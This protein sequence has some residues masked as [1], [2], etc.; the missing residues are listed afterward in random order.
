MMKYSPRLFLALL[1]ATALTAPHAAIAQVDPANGA[2]VYEAPNGVPIVDIVNPDGN[3]LSHNKFNQYNVDNRG[4]ILNNGTIAQTTH[5]SQLAGQVPANMN[6]G[7]SATVILN[8]VVS[9]NRS[10]LN[11]FTEV[12]GQ[13]ADVIVANPYGITCNGCGFINAPNATLTTGAPQF[14][15]GALTGFRTEEGD[16]L[17]TGA[18][19]NAQD[20]DYLALV[21]RSVTVDGQVNASDLDVVAGANDW[22][23]NNKTATARAGTGAAPTVAID[24]SALGGMYANK[25]RLISTEN[26]VGVKMN[27]EAAAGAGDF[28]L[29]ATGKIEVNGK[30]SSEENVSITTTQAGADAIKATNTKI[31]AKKDVGVTANTG[32]VELRGGT[33]TAGEDISITAQTIDDASTVDAATDNNKRYAAGNLDLYA[34]GNTALNGI[35]HGAGNTLRISG[36]GNVDVGADGA[37]LYG[38]V[39]TM[40]Y[41]GMTS[42]NA[43][44]VSANKAIDITS[45]QLLSLGAAGVIKSVAGPVTINAS[46]GMTNAGKISSGTGALTAEVSGTLTNS[47]TMHAGTTLTLADVLGNASQTVTNTG[48]LLADGALSFKAQT[49]NNNGTGIIQGGTGAGTINVTGTLTNASAAKIILSTDAAGTGALTAGTLANSGVTQAAG[50]LALTIGTALTNNTGAKVL[51]GG[52]MTVRGLSATD[53]AVNNA[54]LIQSGGLLDIKGN[55]GGNAVNI[56]GTANGAS[57]IGKA[58]DM[59]GKAFSLADGSGITADGNLNISG[60]TLTLSGSGAYIVAANGGTGTGTITTSGAVSN[61]GMIFSADDLNV[62]GL[63]VTNN[64]TGG[65]AA[66]DT[67]RVRSTS[68]DITNNGALYA[69][70]LLDVNANSTLRNGSA[71]TMDSG[72]DMTLTAYSFSNDGGDLNAADAL[73]ISA[74]LFYNQVAGGDQRTWTTTA[75]TGSWSGW[76][77]DPDWLLWGQSATRTY[78]STWQRYQTYTG[79]TPTKKPQIIAGNSIT[80]NNFSYGLNLGGIISANTVNI[81]SSVGGSTFTN[82]AYSLETQ[83]WKS[84]YVQTASCCTDVIYITYSNG[85]TNSF[86]DSSSSTSFGGGIYANT[87]NA[88]GFTL[89]NIA[90]VYAVDVD[91][92]TK[93]GAGTASLV[94]GV[95]FGGITITLPTNPNGFFVV[96][97]DPNSKYLVETNPRFTTPGAISSDY[98]A[99]L[100]GINPET[101]QKRLGDANYEAYLIR[102]QLIAEVGSNII[103]PG[104]SEAQQ[105]QRLMDQGA[106]VASVMGLEYGKPLTET[107]IASL[108][109]DMVWMVETEVN[110][111]K[112][113]APVVYLSAATQSM[114]DA[115]GANIAANNVNMDLDALNNTGGTIAGNNTLNIRTTGD[116]TNTS[117]TIRGG[118]V[119]LE[120]TEGSIINQTH[121]QHGGNDTD[122]STVI[123]K[124]AG[125]ESTGDLNMKAAQDITN[126]GANVSAGGNASLDA[127]G[128][129]TFDTIEDRRATT[130]VNNGGGNSFTGTNNTTTTESSVTN[131]GSNLKVG[132]NL[133]TNSG[134]DTTIRGSTVDVA[135]DGSMNAGGDLRILDVQNETTSKTTSTTSGVG[136]GGGVYGT[137]EDSTERYQSKSAGSSVNFGGNADLNAGG[138]MTVQGS[139]VGAGGNM[140]LTADEIEILEGRNID[141]TTQTTSTTTYLSTDSGSSTSSSSG[142]SAGTD[143]ASAQA[144]ASAETGQQGNADL[145]LMN[146]TT[147]TT[148]TYSNTGSGSSIR[149]GG[150]MSINSNNDVTVRGSNVE[151]G[152]NVDVNARNVNITASQDINTTTTTT[153][154]TSVGFHTSTDNRAGAEASAG[155][156]ADDGGASANA[157]GGRTGAGAG[158]NAGDASAGAQ[159]GASAEASTDN[160]LDLVRHNEDST[161]TTSITNQAAGIKSGGNM[162]INAENQLNVHGSDIE[163]G[164]DV[165]LKAK[166]MSFTAAEDSTVTT[167]TSSSTAAGL[168]AEGNAGASAGVEG[169]AGARTGVSGS[170]SADAGAEAGIGLYGTNTTSSSTEGSTTAR[171]STIKSGGN[172]TREA[173]GKITDVGTQIEAGGNFTQSAEEWDSRAAENRTFSSSSS[174]SN[175]AKLGAYGEASASAGASGEAGLGMPSTENESS[176]GASAGGKAS[177]NRETEDGSSSSSTAVTSNIKAGGMMTSTTT[178]K[179]TMEGTNLESGG[180]MT[181]NAGSLDYRAAQ[182]TESSSTS[183]S[184]ID[185]EL[186]AGVDATKAV[187]G[188]ISGGYEADRESSSSSTAVTGSMKSGGNLKVNTTGDARF[189]GTNIEAAGDAGIKAGGDVTFDAARNASESS[190]SGENASASLSASKSGKGGGKGGKGMGLEAEGGFNNSQSESSDAV[191]GSIKSG[192]NL[193]ISS[194]GNATFEGTNLESGGDMGVEAKGDVNF[195]AAESTSSSESYGMDV[196]VSASKGG[197]DKQGKAKGTSVGGEVSGNYSMSDETTAQESN[198]KSGGNIKIKSGNDTNLEGT[199][200][201]STGKTSIGAGGDVNFKAK[202]ESSTSVDFEGSVSAGKTSGA[203]NKANNGSEVGVSADVQ[204]GTSTTRTGGNINAGAIDV[205]S[206]GNTTFEGTNLTSDGDT[207]VRAGGDVRFDAAESSSIDGSFRGSAGSGGGMITDAGIG[208]GV[209]RDGSDVNTGGNLNIQSGGQTSFTGTQ[210]DVGGTANIDAAGGV[211]KNTAVS[212]GGQI[213]TSRIGAEVDVQQTNIR[214]RGGVNE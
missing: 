209:T 211:E 88:S 150:N 146:N 22:D 141:R 54:G 177:Y 89:N 206:G 204:G 78:T 97:K 72:N 119:N 170:A 151:A 145:S 83:N 43:A 77:S 165:N 132:G 140:N 173:E 180:D 110:G 114:F 84:T 59:S 126:K 137:Q 123:G 34:T 172:M 195:N 20:T 171:T 106:E 207:S 136:V 182:N 111:V 17:I 39:I 164:G 191:T 200:I 18:G 203:G 1:T 190:S 82:D 153:T 187:T 117:G 94:S 28:T 166:D 159:A 162:T 205:Q 74:T 98:L 75:S 125:I 102:Q 194:G 2:T 63:S 80:I 183:T 108:D 100:L 66:G 179:T 37:T 143:G 99:K 45:D 15:G 175:T 135:G 155:A 44:T 87:L 52:N 65:I 67:L 6:L 5:A 47:G 33:V 148:E 167:T 196:S 24:S 178:G 35:S 188:S 208:G 112:V 62:T 186:K 144:G 124:T 32:A 154:S 169:N 213:G 57:F 10:A 185:A 202:E 128:N 212:G 181:L 149:S 40:G 36:T 42:L 96:S 142:A 147:T 21:A 38:D 8:E 4:L 19:M 104:E 107:Q 58:V 31:S 76:S 26:G 214:A 134:G 103:L 79:G 3:G 7:S 95:S 48:S 91:S 198:L 41:G 197:K 64:A 160:K 161:S 51:S 174:E 131:I 14:A 25:I 105:M 176:A 16:I 53:Y 193:D 116:M 93:A 50:T 199:N 12:T 73:T 168:Y 129:I 85:P 163:A 118:D 152:G 30:I 13:S 29:S 109:R 113:L 55:G 184:S 27:G 56:S 121:A 92:Q 157:Q 11:G 101:L 120:S 138:T 23:H 130:T 9:P 70:T 139:E 158:V 127:G 81:S 156:Q 86:I 90:S 71:G 122:G 201:E 133:S 115:G 69:G 61:S 60:V 189:E 49:F 210:A 192:G 46:T 68:G